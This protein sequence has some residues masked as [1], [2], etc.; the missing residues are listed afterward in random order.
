VNYVDKEV[1]IFIQIGTTV[2]SLLNLLIEKKIL[3]SPEGALP[4]HFNLSLIESDNNRL[5]LK[6]ND[7]LR[8]DYN[9]YTILVEDLLLSNPMPSTN[10]TT[11]T[12]PTLEHPLQRS[13]IF[14][15]PFTASPDNS[16][17]ASLLRSQSSPDLR[18]NLDEQ[19]HRLSIRQP[20]FQGASNT[21]ESSE[22]FILSVPSTRGK[23]SLDEVPANIEGIRQLMKR[24]CWRSVIK[25]CDNCLHS[26]S[27][28]S[29][30]STS[31]TSLSS[32]SSS[33]SSSLS[34][35]SA[36]LKTSSVLLNTRNSQ[37]RSYR[38][39][40]LQLKFCK[41]I[42]QVK[43]RMYKAASDECEDVGDFDD[44]VNCYENYP[45]YYP[46]RRGSMVPFGM[47]VLR[48]NLPYYLKTGNSLDPLY[49]L[50]ALCR[51]HI[52]ILQ[53]LH[54]KEDCISNV[55]IESDNLFMMTEFPISSSFL[56]SLGEQTET[57]DYSML[58]EELCQSEIKEEVLSTW[59]RREKQVIFVIVIRL[60]LEKNYPAAILLLQEEVR[61]QPN[62][63]SLLSTLGRIHL[64]MG[65]VRFAAAIFKQVENTHTEREFSVMKHMN[66]G[67]LAL[68]QDQF[69]LAVE[70][71]T[72]VLEIDS[73]N[74]SA[75]NNKAV[76]LLYTSHLH[77]AITVLEDM[78]R[79]NPEKSLNESTVLNL[80]TLYELQGDGS[81]E[82][83]R[84]IMAQVA[85]Y[86]ND[87]FDFSSLKLSNA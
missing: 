50:L 19:T 49:E 41:M 10:T 72:S 54:F 22:Q 25:L 87:S 44:K 82:K 84:A 46:N 29:S 77:D 52:Q 7:I 71:F 6:L 32:S 30:T 2:L 28:V 5:K 17:P 53:S 13:V 40:I 67:F 66:S 60:V 15:S 75:L 39:D 34:S 86:A 47:R 45:E 65:N 20:Q 11:A 73:T 81:I 35:S 58:S 21:S 3:P 12:S 33:S 16:L 27:F 59:R 18:K 76:C 14:S 38:H 1:E 69:A 31:N 63:V 24:G 68:A 51:K 55:P 26:V 74:I 56:A 43:M 57:F 23:L 78:I 8:E 83:K 9:G 36:N 61:N 70:H 48:A 64:Q 80:C 37:I 42:A 4:T 79:K 62:D 85:K